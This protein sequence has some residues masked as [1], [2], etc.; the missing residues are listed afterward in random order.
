ML[1][2]TSISHTNTSEIAFSPWSRKYCSSERLSAMC[3]SNVFFVKKQTR[4][5]LPEAHLRTTDNTQIL[6][7]IVL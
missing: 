4:I 3:E 7:C 2:R 6:N 1:Q 5:Q